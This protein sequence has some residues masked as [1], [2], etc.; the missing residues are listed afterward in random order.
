MKGKFI[1][2][3]GAMGPNARGQGLEAAFVL[4]RGP[5]QID[6]DPVALFVKGDGHAKQRGL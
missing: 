6:G 2:V 1:E 4:R 3:V 5:G